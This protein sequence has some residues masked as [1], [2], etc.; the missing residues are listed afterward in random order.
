MKEAKKT[1][2]KINDTKSFF[3]KINKIVKSLARITKKKLERRL[4]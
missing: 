4:K 2:E 1:I 3:K